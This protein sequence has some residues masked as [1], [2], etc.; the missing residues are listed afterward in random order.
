[1]SSLAP[2]I[3]ELESALRI[4]EKERDDLAAD[5]ERLCLQ[6]GSSMFNPNYLLT[7]RLNC[8]ESEA[9]Q[10]R[11]QLTAAKEDRERLLE[12]LQLARSAKIST[13]RCA[14][15]LSERCK[16]LE[17]DVTFYK[18]RAVKAMAE[19]D[20]SIEDLRADALRT[21]VQFDE[22]MGSLEL[23][24]ASKKELEVQ[25]RSLQV[26]LDQL[27]QQAVREQ[28]SA[29]AE[30]EAERRRLQDTV[31]HLEDSTQKL[32]TQLM[33]VQAE[34][35]HTH[36][37]LKQ[38]HKIEDQLSGQLRELQ[39]ELAAERR[40]RSSGDQSP[41]TSPSGTRSSPSSA[42]GAPVAAPTG[43]TEDRFLR[44]S[45]GSRS[46]VATIPL[47]PALR[48]ST[49]SSPMSPS[50]SLAVVATRD[51]AKR[52]P[53][54][55]RALSA[56]TTVT[57]TVTAAEAAAPPLQ[58]SA[59]PDCGEPDQETPSSS[60]LER[61]SEQRETAGAAVGVSESALESLPDRARELEEMLAQVR[62]E[63]S[64][65]R[66]VHEDERE[67]LQV[68][69]TMAHDFKI[70]LAQAT[71]EKVEALLKAAQLAQTV[72]D[73]QQ[74][75]NHNHNQVQQ[76]TPGAG[77]PG[78]PFVAMQRQ[79][80]LAS[81]RVSRDFTRSPGSSSNLLPATSAPSPPAAG[82]GQTSAR[83]LWATWLGGSGG[84]WYGSSA[85]TVTATATASTVPIT[86]ASSTAAA[87]TPPLPSGPPGAHVTGGGGLP[88]VTSEEGFDIDGVGAVSG[89]AAAASTAAVVATAHAA[90]VEAAEGRSRRLAAQLERVRS[91][92]AAID[93]LTGHVGRCE[94]RLRSCAALLWSSSEGDAPRRWAA[95]GDLTRLSEE[96]IALRT[97]AGL[98]SAASASASGAPPPAGPH[99]HDLPPVLPL[100]LAEADALRTLPHLHLPQHGHVRNHG[101]GAVA[102]VASEYDN[103]VVCTREAG[104]VQRRVAEVL[105]SS[106]EFGVRSLEQYNHQSALSSVLYN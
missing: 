22:L 14:A 105:L 90:T 50:S 98:S 38:A 32:K 48:V 71:Q 51:A 15:E 60:R 91:Q 89:A 81:E 72:A 78:A 66:A 49:S 19:R 3:A 103:S 36:K 101:D 27:R 24:Q 92:L 59:H 65:E 44:T 37:L 68:L 85:A 2:R 40:Q 23:A 56:S 67:Q 18:E 102:M 4:V 6:S 82:G 52:A 46:P 73:A 30:G 88:S 39:A 79:G 86:T 54:P 96:C 7:E 21:Q 47:H 75:H 53:S 76:L 100:A 69:R 95:L 11:Q 29:N 61:R 25:L 34:A 26:E 1:M 62:E 45:P 99:F 74:H 12:E 80:S 17:R 31:Q 57:V 64:R 63:L 43:A 77:Q 58:T 8:A 35:L 41:Q 83:S 13:E 20:Q 33:E 70:K 93:R 94:A 10:V 84:G 106:L 87:L 9:R 5:V 16:S 97:E 28:H 42:G 104:G 55:R